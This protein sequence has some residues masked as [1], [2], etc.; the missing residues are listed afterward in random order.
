M[1]QESVEFFRLIP[2]FC[3]IPPNHKSISYLHNLSKIKKTYKTKL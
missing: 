1:K 2:V 3:F